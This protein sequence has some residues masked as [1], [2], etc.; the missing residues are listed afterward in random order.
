MNKLVLSVNC[1]SSSIKLGLY[2]Y[3]GLQKVWSGRI[4]PIGSPA[5]RIIIRDMQ[6]ATLINEE[7][8]CPDHEAAAVFITDWLKS[9]MLLYGIVAVGHRIVHDGS[10]F[11]HAETL[12]DDVLAALRAAVAFARVHMTASLETVR[13]FREAFPGI[14]HVAVFDTSFHRTLPYHAY[15]YPIPL[16]PGSEIIRKY[17]FHG[18]S[19]Q[20]VMQ[21]L[22]SHFPVHAKG[23]VI[24]AHLGNGASVTAVKEGIS[25]DTS[26]GLTPSGGMVMA[27]RCGDMD[28]GVAGYLLASGKAEAGSLDEL[29]SRQSGLKALCGYTDMR[30]ILSRENSSPSCASA[31]DIFCYQARKYIGAM[32]AAIG[33]IDALVFTGGIGENAPAIRSRI[34]EGLSFLGIGLDRVANETGATSISSNTT[35]VYVLPANEERIIAAETVKEMQLNPWQI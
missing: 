18:L 2:E 21:Q 34:C 15:C 19:C 8:D 27:T 23:R 9:Q 20:S 25:A 3:P 17:G 31:I 13:I 32:A 28:P 22:T 4:D 24:I 7:I 29:F 30:E 11:D 16:L 12:T 33:G 14:D 26:M 10:L 6:N 35:A 1:G 5:A